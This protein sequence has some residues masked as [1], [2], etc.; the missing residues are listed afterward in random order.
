MDSFNL[1]VF[2]SLFNKI[3][4]SE[5]IRELLQFKEIITFNW[6]R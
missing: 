5:K 3:K 2:C 4:E 6:L 1:F